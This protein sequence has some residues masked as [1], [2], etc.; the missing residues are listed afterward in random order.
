MSEA[1]RKTTA[2]APRIAYEDVGQGEPALLFLP[3]WA[4]DHTQVDPTARLSAEHRRVLVLDWPGHGRSET[5][6]ADF[7]PP[8][9]GMTRW[10]RARWR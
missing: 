10:S 3:G 6:S 2:A 5:P 7:G 1:M 4:S 9:S 8:T